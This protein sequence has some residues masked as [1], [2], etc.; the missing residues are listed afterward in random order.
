MKK[1]T[2]ASEWGIL[3]KALALS[4]DALSAKEYQNNARHIRKNAEN[5][6]KNGPENSYPD[7]TKINQ[8]EAAKEAVELLGR[9][10]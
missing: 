8:I 10:Q 9:T 1:I 4:K 5:I 6:L 7:K 3:A 2:L